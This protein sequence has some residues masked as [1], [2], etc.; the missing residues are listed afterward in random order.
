MSA[1][2]V[3]GAQSTVAQI[4]W[5]EPKSP[6]ETL[7][8]ALAATLH[9]WQRG[10]A[11]VRKALDELGQALES[12]G[13][14]RGERADAARAWLESN[15]DRLSRALEAYLS[16]G[17]DLEGD[18]ALEAIAEI[19]ANREALRKAEAD[20]ELAEGASVKLCRD[21][22]DVAQ[23]QI[24]ASNRKLT[25]AIYQAKF[26]SLPDLKS[27]AAARDDAAELETIAQPARRVHVALDQ[28]L[29]ASATTALLWVVF[30]GSKGSAD[31]CDWRWARWLEATK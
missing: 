4:V 3:I 12:L 13:R 29:R 10:E 9:R 21:A 1:A 23:A 22:L 7:S 30:E 17:A 27:L 20:F 26:P 2:Q 15:R 5:T 11:S 6:E 28:A 14:K 8:D 31:A 24:R 16:F 18:A 19:E 25:L